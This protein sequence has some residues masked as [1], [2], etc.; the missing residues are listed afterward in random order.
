M[1]ML[2]AAC[3]TTRVAK[4]PCLVP[5]ASESRNALAAILT[6]GDLLL[7]L[8]VP[9]KNR[10]LQEIARFVGARHGLPGRTVYGSLV[11]REAVG[12]TALGC[13]VAVPH[14]R[15]KG[16]SRPIAAFVRMK[17]AIPFDAPDGKPVSDLFVLLVP[18]QATD[19]HLLLLAEVAAMCCDPAFRE[20]L[21][22]CDEAADVHAALARW[23]RS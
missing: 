20:D 11:G 13:G 3:S 5:T 10:A 16:L 18:Q 19:A 8:D 14:A 17:F 15:V 1:T 2:N 9:T 6:P 21:R 22:S 12:S 7:D 4:A 23:R